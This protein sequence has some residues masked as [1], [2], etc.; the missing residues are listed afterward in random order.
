VTAPRLEMI[1]LAG[2]SSLPFAAG[3]ATGQRT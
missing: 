1:N 2:A 3:Y